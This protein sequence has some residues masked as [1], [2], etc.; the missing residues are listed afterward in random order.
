MADVGKI[1]LDTFVEQESAAIGAAM[2][3]GV[4]PSFDALE[5]EV[6]GADHATVGAAMARS[7]GLPDTLCTAIAGHHAPHPEAPLARVV[8]CADTLGLALA[9]SGLDGMLYPAGENCM[10]VFGLK[11]PELDRMILHVSM[12]VAE[13]EE[14]YA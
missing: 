1:A 6:V 14:L 8:H 5:R 3:D 12:R 7:W 10:T 4:Y 13:I 11:Q 9:G 2:A